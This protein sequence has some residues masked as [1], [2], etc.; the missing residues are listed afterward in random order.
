MILPL[1][2][3]ASRDVLCEAPVVLLD[4][5]ERGRNPPLTDRGTPVPR[6]LESAHKLS[7]LSRKPLVL[8]HLGHVVVELLCTQRQTERLSGVP[9]HLQRTASLLQ[10][11]LDHRL[12]FQ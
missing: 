10:L 2:L 9:G 7:L 5:L 1:V 8:H 6:G 11:K 3:G 12:L 4:D